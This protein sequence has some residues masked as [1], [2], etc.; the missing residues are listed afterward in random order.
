MLSIW[1]SSI[2]DLSIHTNWFSISFLLMLP[3]VAFFRWLNTNMLRNNSN[4]AACRSLSGVGITSVS[5]ITESSCKC[6][7]TIRLLPDMP[8]RH[9]CKFLMLVFAFTHKIKQKT[10]NLDGVKQSNPYQFQQKK[11][12][13]IDRDK[14]LIQPSQVTQ[15]WIN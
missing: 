2:I 11:A 10:S 7:R 3:L 13:L 14:L 9:T 5:Y 15:I 6:S 4:S 12:K 8:N 1:L